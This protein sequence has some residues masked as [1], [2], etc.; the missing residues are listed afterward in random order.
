MYV[1]SYKFSLLK[2]S[3]NVFQENWLSKSVFGI[4]E[5]FFE[6]YINV[7]AYLDV[8]S[9]P[10]SKSNV[11]SFLHSYNWFLAI[12]HFSYHVFVFYHHKLEIVFVVLVVKYEREL[13]YFIHSVQI[14]WN[15]SFI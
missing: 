13:W 1:E 11:F 3:G 6:I 5:T 8:E 9:V 14:E 4:G 2:G 7:C 12:I 15:P 10:G